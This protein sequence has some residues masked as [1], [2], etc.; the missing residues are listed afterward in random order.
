MPLRSE[1]QTMDRFAVIG[2]SGMFI[3]RAV[4]LLV[5]FWMG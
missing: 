3:C 1:R 5:S 4:I 2:I